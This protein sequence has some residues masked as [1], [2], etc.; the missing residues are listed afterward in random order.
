MA[1]T[2]LWLLSARLERGGPKDGLERCLQ[3]AHG[4]GLESLPEGG[5]ENVQQSG[6]GGLG[7]KLVVAAGFSDAEAEIA[8]GATLAGAAF[9]GIEP[10]PETIKRAM[11]SGCCDFM[12]NNLD[13]ALRILKNELRKRQ[14]VSIGLLAN[15]AEV[16]AEMAERGVLPDVL[17]DESASGPHALGQYQT[18]VQEW[19]RAAGMAPVAWSGAGQDAQ[20]LKRLDAAALAELPP[21]D[22]MRRRWLQLSPKYFRRDLPQTRVMWLTDPE[23]AR[24]TVKSP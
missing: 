16:F 7:G 8:L 22:A 24:L 5:P 14:P 18:L 23:R 12:V 2:A 3:G 4:S 11:R 15:P 21:E 1:Y 19:S 13:E 10:Q 20:F 6:L 17:A 9:L